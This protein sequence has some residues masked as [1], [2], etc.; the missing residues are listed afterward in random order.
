MKN[1]TP[2]APVQDTPEPSALEK[3]ERMKDVMRRLMAVPK[4]EIAPKP[5][6]HKRT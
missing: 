2:K 5:K 1:K 3:M 4:S 6:R